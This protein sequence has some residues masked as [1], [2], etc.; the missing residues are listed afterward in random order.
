MAIAF[1]VVGAVAV[2]LSFVA[3][4]KAKDSEK[5][6]SSANGLQCCVAELFDIRKP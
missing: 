4:S 6:Q 5:L 2:A 1:S 3:T